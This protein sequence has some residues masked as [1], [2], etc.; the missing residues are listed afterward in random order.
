MSTTLRRHGSRVWPE[1][2]KAI[3][4]VKR[5]AIL[6]VARIDRLAGSLSTCSM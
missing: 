2:A 4:Q 1:L 3:A 6:V 5:G